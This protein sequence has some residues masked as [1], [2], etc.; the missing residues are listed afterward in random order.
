[1]SFIKKNTRRMLGIISA[2]FFTGIITFAFLQSYAQSKN[3]GVHKVDLVEVTIFADKP[4]GA[5]ILYEVVPYESVPT[6]GCIKQLTADIL[7]TTSSSSAMQFS[8]ASLAA[9]VATP[10]VAKQGSSAPKVVTAIKKI[11]SPPEPRLIP[12][13]APKCIAQATAPVGYEKLGA[14]GFVTLELNLAKT[15]RIERGEVEKSSGFAE[16]DIAALAQV[17]NTWQFEPCK[18]QNDI[19]ACKQRIRF[20]WEVK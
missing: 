2:L 12:A 8:S 5:A 9:I 16:L 18:K 20:R 7:A 10:V 4:A 11:P 13:K 3:R 6:D 19:V 17:T 15:G 14:E 1:M